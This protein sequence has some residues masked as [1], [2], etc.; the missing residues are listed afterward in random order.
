MAAAEFSCAGRMVAMRRLGRWMLNGLTVLS[1]LPCVANSCMF[2]L[3]RSS[4]KM[5]SAVARYEP[6]ELMTIV[7]AYGARSGWMGEE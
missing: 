7:G 3:Q 2:L 5:S 4:R 1:L 6:I